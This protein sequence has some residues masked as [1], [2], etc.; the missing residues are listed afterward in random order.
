MCVFKH[1][2]FLFFFG[3]LV[4]CLRYGVI[5]CSIKKNG[6]INRITERD[7][8]FS[9]DLATDYLYIRGLS[10]F[11]SFTPSYPLFVSSFFRF[12]PLLLLLFLLFF[13][14]S[15]HLL[16]FG[17]LNSFSLY[18]Y[19]ILLSAIFCIFLNWILRLLL[20]GTRLVSF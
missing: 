14:S 10:K 11:I 2:N 7:T 5:Y 17:F 9:A 20:S 6:G 12:G 1:L 16:S 4:D 13:V 3:K 15:I 8:A 18:G 19:L